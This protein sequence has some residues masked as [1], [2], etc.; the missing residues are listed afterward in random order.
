MARNLKKDQQVYT[1]SSV[2][3]LLSCKG[4]KN[5]PKGSLAMTRGSI[6]HSILELGT[7]DYDK[8]GSEYRGEY[9]PYNFMDQIDLQEMEDIASLFMNEHPEYFTDEWT[10]EQEIN[11][12]TKSGY[13]ISGIVDSMVIRSTSAVMLDWKSGITRADTRNELDILQAVW[14]SY[15]IFKTKP[16]ITDVAFSFIYIEADDQFININFNINDLSKME[17]MIERFI[18]ATKYTGL[19]V[20]N[21]CKWCNERDSCPLLALETQSLEKFGIKKVK[22]IKG[23]CEA[24]IKDYRDNKLQGAKDSKDYKGFTTVKQYHMNTNQLSTAEKLTFIKDKIKL[25]KKKAQLYEA[26]GKKIE[27]TN[28]YRMK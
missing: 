13:Q 25:T 14:Y 22:D 20:N 9:R 28:S 23:A 21:K 10:K 5:N 15:I 16:T 19:R 7:E 8:V 11:C 2:K 12:T 24:S 3:S 17:A 27:T 18:F 26:Q 4:F 6:L 1:V